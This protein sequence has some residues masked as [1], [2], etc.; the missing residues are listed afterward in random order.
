VARAHQKEDEMSKLRRLLHD[1]A[2]AYRMFKAKRFRDSLVF[3]KRIRFDCS[4]RHPIRDRPFVV[5]Y[6]GAFYVATVTDIA[7]ACKHA[8]QKS[9]TSK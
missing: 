2:W 4:L 8:L 3:S 9:E 6:P 5:D 1:T 7:R